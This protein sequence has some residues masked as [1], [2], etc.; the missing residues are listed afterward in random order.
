M[1]TGRERNLGDTEITNIH[2]NWKINL[3]E[4]A[5]GDGE[6]VGAGSTGEVH[7]SN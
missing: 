1:G 2:G 6:M 3:I 7:V 5:A 4:L